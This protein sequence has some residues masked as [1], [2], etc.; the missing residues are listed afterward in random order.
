M[1]WITDTIA[2]LSLFIA[3]YGWML[4]AWGMQP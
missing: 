2:C 1:K 4:L 3:S